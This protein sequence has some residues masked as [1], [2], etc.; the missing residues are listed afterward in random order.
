M[1]GGGGGGGGSAVSM[2]PLDAA[3]AAAGVDG[4]DSDWTAGATETG[5][6]AAAATATGGDTGRDAAGAADDVAGVGFCAARAEL[7][8]PTTSTTMSV[9]M[10]A[11]ATVVTST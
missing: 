7:T 5:A 11:I 9:A 6:G 2:L 3:T 8:R 4:S 10:T 1:T